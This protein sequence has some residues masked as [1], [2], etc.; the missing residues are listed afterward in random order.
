MFIYGTD[1]EE[2]LV[3]ICDPTS[4]GFAGRGEHGSREKCSVFNEQSTII[5]HSSPLLVMLVVDGES[6][7]RNHILKILFFKILY[8]FS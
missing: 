5:D 8:S 4:D 7:Y 1:S 3:T 2:A 6:L